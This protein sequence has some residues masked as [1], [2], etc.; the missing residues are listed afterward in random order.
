MVKKCKKVSITIPANCKVSENILL[1]ASKFK[2]ISKYAA[3][4]YNREKNYRLDLKISHGKFK[5]KFKKK[6]ISINYRREDH[7]VG[8]YM[9][10]EKH[11]EIVLS[12][13]SSKK[14]LELFIEKAR[15]Y[16]IPQKKDML[17]CYTMKNGFWNVLSKL[18][19][20]SIDTIYLDKKIT[21]ELLGDIKYFMNNEEEYKEFGIPYKKIIL[22]EGLPGTGKTSLIFSIASELNMNI[23]IINFGMDV[24][25]YIFMNALSNIPDNCFLIMED[26]DRLFIQRD[27]TSALSFSG[28]LNTL[29]GL[30]RKD[31]LIVFMTTN[32]RNQLDKALTR[33]CR[34]DKEIHF[35][36]AT[37]FQIKTIYEKMLPKQGH[38]LKSFLEEVRGLKLTM[39]ILTKFLFYFRNED[40]ILDKIG[41]LK[42]MIDQPSDSK[43]M[44]YT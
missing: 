39:A 12:T 31:K 33:P 35:S 40:S 20:R 2:N 14:L 13:Y 38:H 22:L 6:M 43:S 9:G 32:H 41:D 10:P 42:L 5:I 19:K 18:P 29:D 30:G 11:E 27:S 36:Y 24:N 26:I 44:M 4:R 25:D 37:E 21:E 15:K 34:I 1:Y 8:T 7:T 3:S 28:M 17:N 16:N 23:A